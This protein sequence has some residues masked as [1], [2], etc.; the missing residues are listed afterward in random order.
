MA[1][2]LFFSKDF[3]SKNG[4]MTSQP[5]LKWD[6]GRTLATSSARTAKGMY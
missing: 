3:L 1:E 5:L 2:A 6:W 4:E